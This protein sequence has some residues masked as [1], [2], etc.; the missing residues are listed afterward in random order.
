MPQIHV[1]SARH[2]R[3]LENEQA[4]AEF[5]PKKMCI[6]PWIEEIIWL[7]LR[8]YWHSLN[9]NCRNTLLA[10]KTKWNIYIYT[11]IDF[12][13]KCQVAVAAI[14]M[15]R[16]SADRNF[17]VMLWHIAW[18]EVDLILQYSPHG[19]VPG[20]ASGIQWFYCC[21]TSGTIVLASLRDSS[22][23]YFFVV[24]CCHSHITIGWYLFTIR[25]QGAK[26]TELVAKAILIK[27]Q[28]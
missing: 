24:R 8:R 15:S 6:R 26:N 16:C 1:H 14:A 13:S 9:L 23:E 19:M 12:M 22:E 10:K 18:I 25:W 2:E 20:P 27:N 11:Y 17:A 4:A 28:Y 7:L 21:L 3:D 5:C